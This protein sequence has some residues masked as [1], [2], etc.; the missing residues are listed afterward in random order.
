LD[1][2]VRVTGGQ[3]LEVAPSRQPGLAPRCLS[4]LL[5]PN[6]DASFYRPPIGT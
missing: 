2:E 1:A 4:E 3:R 6:F 5:Y